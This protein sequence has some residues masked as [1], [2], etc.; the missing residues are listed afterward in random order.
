MVAPD[1]GLPGPSQ[2]APLLL[3]VIDTL[4][5]QKMPWSQISFLLL[6]LPTQA[7]PKLASE[8]CWLITSRWL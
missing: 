5:R 1:W 3:S 2:T 8:C 4:I 7:C 6:S